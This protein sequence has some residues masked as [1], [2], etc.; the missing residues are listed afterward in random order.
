MRSKSK[1]EDERRA[2]TSKGRIDST[3][4]G[5]LVEAIAPEELEPINDPEC[6]HERLVR[7]ESE[8]D[9][10]AFMCANSDCGIVVVFDK[11]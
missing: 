5:E 11:N 9:F 1:S 7:D 10:N 3:H 6:K 8:K 2:E 4:G